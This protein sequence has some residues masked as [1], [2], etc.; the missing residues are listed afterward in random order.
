MSPS[1]VPSST[2][3]SDV[4]RALFRIAQF[5]ANS[6]MGHID[7][8]RLQLC[9]R[10]YHIIS[11]SET[12]LCPDISDSIVAI[13][14]Y[15]FIRHDRVVCRGGRVAYFVDSS[16]NVKVLAMSRND[17]IDAPEFLFLEICLPSDDRLLFASIYRRPN[18]YLFGD[19]F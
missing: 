11:V 6:L 9:N 17:F 1:V 15:S 13:D 7:M 16:L 5:N 10:H 4:R 8:L 12:W 19:F 2:L 3:A 18:G 14:N